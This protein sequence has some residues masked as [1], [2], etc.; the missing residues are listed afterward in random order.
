MIVNLPAVSTFTREPGSEFLRSA[1]CYVAHI[2]PCAP[3]SVRV[4]HAENSSVVADERCQES[5][6]AGGS[7]GARQQY[8]S[9][10]AAHTNNTPPI[11]PTIAPGRSWSAAVT[12][13]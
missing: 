6:T 4:P 3:E 2:S 5:P 9:H 13:C 8:S 11:R 12:F 7:S 1:T 10:I